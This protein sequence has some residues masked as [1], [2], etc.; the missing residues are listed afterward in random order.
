[1]RTLAPFTGLVV[2]TGLALG[3]EPESVT[4]TGS[5]AFSH[6]PGQGESPAARN[7]VA[8]LSHREEVPLPD[9]TETKNPTGNAIFHLEDG[10]ALS[11]RLIVANIENVTQSHIHCGPRG[12]A[13]PVVAFLFGFV[14]GGVTTNGILAEGVVT[15]ADIIPRPDSPECPGGLADFDDLLAHMRAGNAYVNVHTVQNPPGEIRGQIRPA[16]PKH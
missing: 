12:V 1:M 14:E 9:L 16:G 8:P 13:G 10:A 5:P 7:F 4:P 15:A 2:L 6:Q 3:C 11:Y